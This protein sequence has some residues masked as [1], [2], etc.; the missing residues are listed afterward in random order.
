MDDVMT[1]TVVAVVPDA[2][3]KEIVAAMEQWKVTAMPVLEGEGRVVGVVSEADLLVKEE[4]HDSDP[5]LIE[6]MRRLDD[7]AK[8]YASRKLW[9]SV[10]KACACWNRKPCAESG[11]SFTTASGISAAVR[12]EYQG[13]IIRSSSPLAMNTGCS[14]AASRW[15]LPKSALGPRGGRPVV[16]GVDRTPAR[17]PPR[18]GRSKTPPWRPRQRWPRQR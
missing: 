3:F 15:S 13:R 10:A 12:C 17:S 16:Q 8:A 7:T 1:R 14:M 4:L 2:H 9:T 6:Q 11:Y 5:G 18:R